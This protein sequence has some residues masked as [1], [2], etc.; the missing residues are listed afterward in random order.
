MNFVKPLALVALSIASMAHAASYR[1]DF[2][3]TGYK[4]AFP[5]LP[6]IHPEVLTGH[7]IVDATPSP[8]PSSAT[9][10]SATT[11]TSF[12]MTIRGYA[13]TLAD[14]DWTVGGGGQLELYGLESDYALYARA[15]DFHLVLPAF[16]KGLLAESIGNMAYGTRTTNTLFI[17]TGV[18]ATITALPVPEASAVAMAGVGLA[19]A[20]FAARRRQA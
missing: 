4:V 13:Y 11:L 16:D 15:D 7:L 1:V 10:W 14:I 18:T 9:G 5:R 2:S 12:E 20:A 6:E 19:M 17:S 3:T 8:Y